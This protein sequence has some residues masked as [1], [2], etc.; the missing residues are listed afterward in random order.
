MKFIGLFINIYAWYLTYL[1]GDVS[2]TKNKNDT[3][4]STTKE[5][6]ESYQKKLGMKKKYK[7]FAAQRH[8]YE[9]EK[10]KV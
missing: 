6:T 10:Q 2:E 8:R 5:T 4:F 3:A 1:K 7:N 9:E